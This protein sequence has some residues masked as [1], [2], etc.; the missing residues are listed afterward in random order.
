MYREPYYCSPVSG[1]TPY[2]QSPCGYSGGYPYDYRYPPPPY[3][4]PLYNEP[5]VYGRYRRN[6]WN[7][8]GGGFLGSLVGCCAGYLLCC[9][10]DDVLD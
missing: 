5:P 9:C 2:Y 8:F 4:P 6:N 1:C 7:E 10:L 3:Y